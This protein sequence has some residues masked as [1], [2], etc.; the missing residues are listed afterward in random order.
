MVQ[1]IE[2]MQAISMIA[3]FLICT[4]F[5]EIGVEDSKTN[6]QSA[7]KKTVIGGYV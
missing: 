2:V 7:Y 6:F 4:E 1:L 3:C 5:C